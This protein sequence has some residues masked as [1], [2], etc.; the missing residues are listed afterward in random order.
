MSLLET[1]L[2]E[3]Q[4]YDEILVIYESAI[5]EGHD[6]ANAGSTLIVKLTQ[7]A[8]EDQVMLPETFQNCLLLIQSLFFSP[9]DIE[10]NNQSGLY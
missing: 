10:Y 8:K 6:L 3:E 5:T 7:L 2:V 4:F 1:N 9:N